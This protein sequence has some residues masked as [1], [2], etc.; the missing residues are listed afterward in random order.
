MFG[1]STVDN[2]LVAIFTKI[3]SARY[4]RETKK[5][6]YYTSNLVYKSHKQTRM[7]YACLGKISYDQKIK[8]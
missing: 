1:L 4:Q 3:P 6:H 8:S 5:L 2:T 7:F